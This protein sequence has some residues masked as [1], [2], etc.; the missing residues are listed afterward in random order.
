MTVQGTVVDDRGGQPIRKANVQL[1]L[2]NNEHKQYTAVS[3]ADGRFRIENLKAGRYE[4]TTDHPGYVQSGSRRQ[5]RVMLGQG[6]VP[7]DL[8]LH[9]QP[10]AVITGNRRRRR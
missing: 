9:M 5:S 8:V 2:L 10:A 7:A 3:D 4:I 6:E 1:L